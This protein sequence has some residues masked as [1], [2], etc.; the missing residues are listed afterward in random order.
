MNTFKSCL[1]LLI[2]G[3]GDT[4]STPISDICDGKSCATGPIDRMGRVAINTALNLSDDL[5]KD[6]YN[7]EPSIQDWAKNTTF[8][9][10][11]EKNLETFD[12][13]DGRVDWALASGIH[14]LRDALKTDVLIVDTGK[15]CDSS[16]NFCE[17]GYLEIEAELLLGGPAHSSCGGRTLNEDVID[18]T[19]TL[20]VSKGTSAV[21]DGVNAATKPSTHTFPYL[22]EPN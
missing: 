11:F 16:N 17:G 9:V 8:D 18:K 6:A 19:L 15:K 22:P 13:L 3:C 12:M 20:L 4:S 10:N 2:I 21:A 14:P 5:A 1:L 7:Q